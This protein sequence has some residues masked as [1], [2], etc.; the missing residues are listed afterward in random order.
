MKNTLI[1]YVDQTTD[2]MYAIWGKE[3]VKGLERRLQAESLMDAIDAQR[4]RYAIRAS[5]DAPLGE[6]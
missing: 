6:A 5:F 3:I 1:R 2:E 4:A